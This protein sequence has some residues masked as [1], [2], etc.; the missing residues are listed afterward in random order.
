MRSAGGREADDAGRAKPCTVRLR[1]EI[2]RKDTIGLKVPDIVAVVIV[3]GR[4][5]DIP[6][7]EGRVGALRQGR[8]DK[9]RRDNR[10]YGTRAEKH[11]GCK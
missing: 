1:G 8:C 7:Q 4:R 2:A 6:L 3:P 10:R 11:R 9:G 5:R